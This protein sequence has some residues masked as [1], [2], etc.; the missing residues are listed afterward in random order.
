MFSKIFITLLFTITLSL[1]I[2]RLPWTRSNKMALK[3]S[4][5]YSQ[6]NDEDIHCNSM[7]SA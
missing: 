2:P 3:T 5:R 6:I 7:I 1:P 4:L